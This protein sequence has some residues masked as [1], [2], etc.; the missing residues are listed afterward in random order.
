[1]TTLYKFESNVFSIQTR[2]ELWQNR[3]RSEIRIL[4][5][6][7]KKDRKQGMIDYIDNWNTLDRLESQINIIGVT[8]VTLLSCFSVF[9]F[10]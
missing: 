6:G 10:L 9:T 4:K 2:H 8:L 5:D 3:V 1:M 7:I